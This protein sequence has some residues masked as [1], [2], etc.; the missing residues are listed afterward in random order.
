MLNPVGHQVWLRH[1]LL[2][3]YA[4]APS[5]IVVFQVGAIVLGHIA[6]AVSAHDKALEVV[7]AGELRTGQYPM[8]TLMVV[9]TGLGITVMSAG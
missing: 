1:N 9:Y 2:Q 8:L 5:L 7:R 6:G 3:P 4:L